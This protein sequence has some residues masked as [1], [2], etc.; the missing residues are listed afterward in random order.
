MQLSTVFCVGIPEFKTSEQLSGEIWQITLT[1]AD[2][3]LIAKGKM[4][5]VVKLAEVAKAVKNKEKLPLDLVDGTVSLCQSLLIRQPEGKITKLSL[6]RLLEHDVK[7]ATTTPR[8]PMPT[9]PLKPNVKGPSR[10]VQAVSNA[11]QNIAG[12][13]S[14]SR[15]QQVTSPYFSP[16]KD[17]TS[18][19]KEKAEPKRQ[20]EIENDPISDPDADFE[21]SSRIKKVPP[22]TRSYLID[23]DEMRHSR[24]RPNSPSSTVTVRCLL[25]W[26][27]CTTSN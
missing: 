27:G 9:F 14:P 20:R 15:T 11:R 17:A 21:D 10:A 25:S 4:V 5:N 7:K 24:W 16:Q 1:W 26:I 19:K 23:P 12:P 6:A 18:P 8:E 13:M 22:P 3:S 2:M